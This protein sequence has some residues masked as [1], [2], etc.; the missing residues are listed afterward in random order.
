MSTTTM[1][2]DSPGRPPGARQIYKALVEDPVSVYRHVGSGGF[3]VR[4]RLFAR[5]ATAVQPHIVRHVLVT[6]AGR[7]RKTPIA[8]ALLEPLLGRGLLTSEGAFWRRQ[9]RIAAPAFHRKRIAGF[10]DAMAELAEDMQRGWQPAAASGA[11]LD[12]QSEMSRVTM[13]IIAQAMFSDGLDEEEARRVG[14][15][16]RAL[17]RHRLRFRDFIGVPEWLPRLP[18]LRVRAAVRVIDRTVNRLIAERRADPRDRGD[19]LSMFMLAE[20]EETGERM[21]DRQLRDEVITMFMAGHETTATALVWTLHALE[22]HPEVEAR[23]HA[24]V[25]SVLSDRPP[26]LADLERLPWTRMTVEETMRL[27]PTVPMISRQAVED[28]EI[29]GQR[30][31]RG[32]LVNLNIWLAHRDPEMWPDPE[33]FDPGRFDPANRGGRPKHAYF[34]FGGGPRVCIGN[35]FAMMEAHIIL[36]SVARHWRLRAIASHEVH[37]VGSV[38]LRPRG[39]L[40]MKLERRR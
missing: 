22:R 38:V 8:R 31:P 13:K 27:H 17:D 33:R 2:T 25:D 1:E 19:L 35:G 21:T 30:V 26:R 18:D 23:L 34:P 28:D 36:A 7:Y 11:A 24:E 12:M 14:D 32:T 15:A 39:G 4:R 10:A 5:V 20:D 3:R 6:R 16:I 9:R 40:P 37:A 29:D